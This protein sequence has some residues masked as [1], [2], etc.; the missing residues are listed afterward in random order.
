MSFKK[1]NLTRAKKLKNHLFLCTV[2]NFLFFIS[3]CTKEDITEEI[4]DEVITTPNSITGKHYHGKEAFNFVNEKKLNEIIGSGQ[5]RDEYAFTI[6]YSEV[7]QV[8]ED[9][10]GENITVRVNH[11][12]QKPFMFYNL[13]ISTSLNGTTARLLEYTM[14]PR[15]FNSY[16]SGLTTIQEFEGLVLS[17]LMYTSYPCQDEEDEMLIIAPYGDYNLV[18]PATGTTS[19]INLINTGFLSGTYSGT[20]FSGPSAAGPSSGGGA[21][22]SGGTNDPNIFPNF[23]D[24]LDNFF[25][26][27][28][29]AFSDAYEWTG[30]TIRTIFR[31]IRN[32]FCGS[33]GPRLSMARGPANPITIIDDNAPPASTPAPLE[34]C[35]WFYTNFAFFHVNTLVGYNPNTNLTPTVLNW[36]D[37]TASKAVKVSLLNF[38]YRNPTISQSTWE[39]FFQIV[40]YLMNGGNASV[41]QEL[42][43]DFMYFPN[44]EGEDGGD[45]F[46]YDDYSDIE[47]QTQTLPGRNDFY[48]AFPKVGA[49]GM[50]SPQV[51]ELIGGHPYQAHQ[52]NDPN[53]QNACALRV[54]R[55][56]NYTNRIIPIFKNNNNEQKTEKGDDNLNY[57]LDAAS[58]LAYMKK[59]FPNNTPLHLVDKTPIE[60]KTA[61]QGKW[62]IY[63][64]IPKDRGSFGASG[65]ADFWSN[66]GCLSGCYFD[67]AKEVYFW[68]LF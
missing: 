61:L 44:V 1:I 59:T 17:Q 33:C 18:D 64:M 13:V 36:W 10:V 57:I 39:I 50:P 8:I 60:I 32:L 42:I 47:T 15:F 43:N 67:K 16:S 12:N 5:Y 11:P 34:S 24:G 28:G 4:K 22:G 2:F 55:A 65:H 49:A 51:Y 3:S 58:L 62:G 9:N 66:T 25:N 53:Y 7:I 48:A 31:W 40:D 68:E 27:I 41:V 35:D 26:S 30:N 6:D 14:T 38:L 23:T 37:L 63:I 19:G 52:A 54:S 46:V 21:S 45:E 29:S 20:M 56:L